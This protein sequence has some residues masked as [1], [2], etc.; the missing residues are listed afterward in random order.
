MKN[1]P[2]VLVSTLPESWPIRS[3]RDA[4]SLSGDGIFLRV[5]DFSV[6]GPRAHSVWHSAQAGKK[7]LPS[8][9]GNVTR[10]HLVA[11]AAVPAASK[12]QGRYSWVPKRPAAGGPPE[13]FS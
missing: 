11:K 12:A 6:A 7:P 3:H 13:N 1:S 9:P 8:H 2:R 10:M 4:E 5:A